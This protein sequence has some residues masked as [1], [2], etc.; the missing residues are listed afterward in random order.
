MI[1]DLQNNEDQ[2]VYFTGPE[3]IFARSEIGELLLDDNKEKYLLNLEF[4][5]K[6]EFLE[7]QKSPK[8]TKDNFKELCALVQQRSKLSAERVSM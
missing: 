4:W 7:Y 6:K 3:I 2:K 8:N 5:A 1:E